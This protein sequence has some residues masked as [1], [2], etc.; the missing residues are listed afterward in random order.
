MAEGRVGLD[1]GA[2]SLGDVLSLARRNGQPLEELAALAA[3]LL[4]LPAEPAEEERQLELATA[5]F[6][7]AEAVARN[8]WRRYPEMRDTGAH[9]SLP[10]PRA[11][12][13]FAT[14]GYV[15]EAG[16]YT[17]TELTEMLAEGKAPASWVARE[18]RRLEAFLTVLPALAAAMDDGT[19]SAVAY[20]DAVE[21][22]A[23]R[24]A[25]MPV[26]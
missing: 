21:A 23:R 4:L 11:A 6:T 16:F 9:G 2:M 25:A 5:A 13:L 26:A 7:A 17:P 19:L 22:L 1:T 10:D 12:Q 18:A 20:S 14:F 3:V 24:F 8:G 15:R